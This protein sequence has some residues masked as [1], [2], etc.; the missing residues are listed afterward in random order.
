MVCPCVL[1]WPYFDVGYKVPIHPPI[2]LE[3]P[4]YR[5]S[6]MKVVCFTKLHVKVE[7]ENYLASLLIWEDIWVGGYPFT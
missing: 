1:S 6:V 4:T 3:G 7:M 2:S 5:D